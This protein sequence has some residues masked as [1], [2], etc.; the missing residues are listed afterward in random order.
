MYD[1]S[2]CHYI[3]KVYIPNPKYRRMNSSSHSS[4]SSSQGIVFPLLSQLAPLIC[5]LVCT[6]YI[7]VSHQFLT[8]PFLTLECPLTQTLYRGNQT[9]HLKQKSTSI[10]FSNAIFDL[11]LTLSYKQCN[12]YGSAFSILAS[13]WNTSNLTKLKGTFVLKNNKD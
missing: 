5:F 9:D 12:S 10:C 4:F 1:N 11:L 2:P 3:S 8:W 7:Q 6:F 13:S